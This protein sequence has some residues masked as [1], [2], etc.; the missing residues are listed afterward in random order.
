MISFKNF[1][2]FFKKSPNKEVQLVSV[3]LTQVIIL[4]FIMFVVVLYF[5]IKREYSNLRSEISDI[6]RNY[7]ESQKDNIKKE[8]ERAV[9]YINFNVQQTETNIRLSLKKSVD[10]AADIALNIYNENKDTKSPTEIKNLIIDALSPIE[11]TGGRYLIGDLVGNIYLLPEM[12][13][14]EGQ[15]LY[16]QRDEMGNYFIQD[17][18]NIIRSDHGGFI[19][20]YWKKSD[21]DTVIGSERLTY[22]KLVEPLNWYIGASEF[23]DDFNSII[24]QEVL[25]WLSNYRFGN[26]GYIFVNTYEGDALLMDGE[27]ILE[28]KNVWN[29]EDPNGIKVIQEERKAV[30]NPDGDFIYYSWRKLTTDEIG[31]KMS[32]VKGIPQWQWM[33]GAGVYIEEI[34]QVLEAKKAELKRNIFKNIIFFVIWLSIFFVM[35]YTFAFYLSKKAQ[36]I[37]QSFIRFFNLA[38]SENIL[39]DESGIN[40]TEFKALASSANKMISEIKLSEERKAHYEKLFE[41]SPEAIV[42][43]NK[44]GYIQ[45]M[46]ASFTEL[47]GYTNIET[48][49]KRLDDLI[50]PP[51]LIKE[52]TLLNRT[53]LE[54]STSQI[55]AIR[56]TKDKKKVYVS[57]IGLPVK[58][59][60]KP[61]GYYII[62]RNITD[63]KEF[64]QQLYTS[65][66]KAEESDRLKT[67]F[68]TNLSH[69][70]RTPLNAIIG[71]STLLNSKEFPKV[72][73]KEYLRLMANSG[74]LLLD[75]IDNIIDISKIESSTLIITKTKSNFNTMLDELLIEFTELKNSMKLTNIELSLKKEISE[76][77]LSIVTDL[78]RLKQI[79]SNLLDNAFKFTEKGL[80]EFGYYIQN[81]NLV[82]YVKDTGIGIGEKD[83][84]FI[85]DQFRQADESTTRKY[86]G[87]GVGLALCKRLVELLGGKLWVESNKD[88][89]SKFSF[90]IPFDLIKAEKN[91]KPNVAFD[92]NVD[93]SSKK[94]LIAEDVEAN[95]K[96]LRTFL[97]R[98]KANI[99]WAK[100]GKEVLKMVKEE[101]NYD[102]ILM[103]INM[104]IMT[105]HEAVEKLKASG[106]KVPVIAQTAYAS[107]DQRFEMQEIG[108]SDYILKPITFQALLQ[109][110]SKFL[111]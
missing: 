87:T 107:D 75:I 103:D 71:F 59:N 93:W 20:N 102:L 23:Y 9:S 81:E 77:E 25:Q 69:E 36:N 96:L 38:S 97:E 18:I 74:K 66:I 56:A 110:I 27:I 86:G 16:Y 34:N 94:I 82:C 29:L 13:E 17:I 78:K 22:V 48:A 80:I 92:D 109:K 60:D 28:K 33:V 55:E 31:Q 47:F 105:G 73:Q 79:F 111:S 7:I 32:F 46:N 37:I 89:G 88:E 65:K 90:T 108:Y 41:K 30:K 15:N 91:N 5:W 53:F 39:I 49:N 42:Y 67:S 4:V 58:L 104:P 19:S 57:I 12:A 26:E 50:V 99:F 11:I 35:I 70:I 100:D 61:I 10:I 106:C 83:Q 54:G 95:Y 51:E 6:Q 76:K 72:D 68:L 85:F 43:L 8:T 101:P 40:L 1:I 62:Y 63:Q 52:A 44:D 45:K 2:N 14:Y 84:E 64:E 21:G 24:K 98:T 3:F